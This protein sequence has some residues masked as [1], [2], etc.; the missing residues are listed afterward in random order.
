MFAV[1]FVLL[2]GQSNLVRYWPILIILAGIWIII[3]TF[4]R[5]K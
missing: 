2:S 5:K 3:Q 1:F 4:F